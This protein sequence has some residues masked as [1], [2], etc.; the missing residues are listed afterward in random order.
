MNSVTRPIANSAL[1]GTLVIIAVVY[2]VWL[3]NTVSIAQPAL[4]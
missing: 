3:L 2:G 4:L 1:A